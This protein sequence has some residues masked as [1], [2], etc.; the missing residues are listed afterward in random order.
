MW[1]EP[2][3]AEKHP[4]LAELLRDKRPGYGQHKITP[5]QK[6]KGINPRKKIHGA[7][8]FAVM[9]EKL[10]VGLVIPNII[11]ERLKFRLK[12]RSITR[13]VLILILEIHSVCPFRQLH[14]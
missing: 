5:I 13:Y 2:A 6:P 14:L 12:I 9:L 7:S 10:I 3:T 1:S 4:D 8:F 11:L